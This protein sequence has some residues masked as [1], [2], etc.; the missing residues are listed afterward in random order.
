MY[1]RCGE[2]IE[3]HH[4]DMGGIK[5]ISLGSGRGGSDNYFSH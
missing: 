1:H 3:K 4:D 2:L 5:K